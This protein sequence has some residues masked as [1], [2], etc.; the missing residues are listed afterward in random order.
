MG[1]PCWSLV[2]FV[3]TYDGNRGIVQIL[4]LLLLVVFSCYRIG[5]FSKNNNCA[6]LYF[7]KYFFVELS[8]TLRCSHCSLSWMHLAL[9]TKIVFVDA[10]DASFNSQ[11]N[12]LQIHKGV[13]QLF[14]LA[15]LRLLFLSSF[16]ISPQRSLHKWIGL[17][18]KRQLVLNR[19]SRRVPKRRTQRWQQRCQSCLRECLVVSYSTQTAFSAKKISKNWHTR[20]K[21]PLQLPMGSREGAIVS[22]SP[23]TRIIQERAEHLSSHSSDNCVLL[24]L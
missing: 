12:R 4:V 15:N 9:G 6:V 8:N 11:C 13:R 3:S 17:Q 18:D 23:M 10:E 14:A 5:I 2:E 21:K 16:Q 24:G 22:L 1:G 19:F 20:W 7:L